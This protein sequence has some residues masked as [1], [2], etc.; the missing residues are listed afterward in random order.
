MERSSFH[1]IGIINALNT[2][3]RLPITDS[4]QPHR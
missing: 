2:A 1:R 3:E 4:T